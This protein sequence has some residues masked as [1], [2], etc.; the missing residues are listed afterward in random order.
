MYKLVELLADLRFERVL[1]Q[2]ARE[3]YG[4]DDPV[5][6][7]K[8]ALKAG[9]TL[10]YQLGKTNDKEEHTLKVSNRSEYFRLASY[11]AKP[12]IEAA[13]LEKLTQT[14]ADV[15]EKASDTKQP[16]KP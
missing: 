5:L 12:L 13:S 6:S 7:A 9:A 11:K 2:E 8:L 4:L 15:G 14:I 10:T 1:G 3:E 16:T